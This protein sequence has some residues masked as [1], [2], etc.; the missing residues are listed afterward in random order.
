MF[1]ETLAV[2]HRR[3]R[4]NTRGLTFRHQPSI[5]QGVKD[6]RPERCRI[7]RRRIEQLRDRAKKAPLE[8][9]QVAAMRARRE[10]CAD[11]WGT[12]LI[13]SCASSM[14][15]GLVARHAGSSRD[16]REQR[17]EHLA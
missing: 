2:F 17:G 12:L 8:R 11:A 10:M 9:V 14:A 6:S 15:R 1:H 7:I 13:D 4:W 5:G 3:I 16:C